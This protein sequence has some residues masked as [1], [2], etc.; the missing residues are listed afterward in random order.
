MQI[1][2][3]ET[4]RRPQPITL[5]SHK[6]GPGQRKTRR[7]NND[8]FHNL[9][10]ELANSSSSKSRAAAEILAKAKAD[11]RHFLPVYDPN[12]KKRSEKVTRYVLLCFH[13]STIFGRV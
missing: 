12:E 3:E 6:Q 8:N 11:A 5:K 10:M 4:S 13:A 1:H 2:I 9:S 7:W